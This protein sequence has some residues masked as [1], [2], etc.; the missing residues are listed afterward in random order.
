MMMRFLTVTIL[1]LFTS[2]SVLAQDDEAVVFTAKVSKDRL[3]VNERLR[4]DFNMN[5]D[6]DNFVPPDFDGFRVLMGPNQAVSR[7]W[8]NGKKSFSKTYTYILSPLSRGSFTIKQAEIEIDG[9]TYKTTPVQ[10]EVTA[11]VDD[12]NVDRTADDVAEESL[13]LVAEVSNANPYLNEAISVVYKLYVSPDISVSNFIPIDNP[14]YNNFWSQDIEVKRWHAQTGLY[15]GEQ[16]RYVVLKKVVLY[17]QKTGELT[18]EP[19]TL[20]VTVEVP[21]NRPG[22]FGNRVTKPVHKTIA[23]GKRTI[24]VKSLPQ[25]GKPAS[26][27]GAVGQF[28][29]DMIT[30]KNDLKANESLTARLVVSGNGNLKLFELPE[31]SLPSALEVYEPEF[32]E[33]ITTT[34]Q[35]MRGKVSQN[36]T[37]VPQLKGKYPIPSVEFS[38]FD[39][40]QEKYMTISSPQSLINVYEGPSG[41]EDTGT[42]VTAMGKK[43]VLGS[44]ASFRFL[45]LDAD[46]KPIGEEP[47]FG[48]NLFYVLFFSPLL[49][50]PVAVLIGRRKDALAQDVEGRKRRQ[51]NRLARKYLSEARKKLGDKEG[52]YE[53]LERALHNYLKAKLHLETSDL[54]KERISLLLSEKGVDQPQIGEFTGLLNSCE[55]AR[56]TPGSHAAM[57]KDYEQAA[58]VISAID[59]QIK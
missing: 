53:S 8:V 33:Q 15:K 2:L 14:R 57:Q 28:D 12:P 55:L 21:T 3:G 58:E 23:A 40:V 13:H 39:P 9:E 45:M 44:G 42:A 38:Y 22:F 59:K 49:L 31:L 7:S 24:S 26:F 51:A 25:E 6:G 54:S 18:I 34:I 46:L 20:D 47:F 1:F 48:S 35:G 37:I 16:Y 30:S 5:K 17:P 52:F 10:I 11:A 56:Y 43:P 29:F 32:E 27:R 19:L 4:V 50:I 36:Y 41:T